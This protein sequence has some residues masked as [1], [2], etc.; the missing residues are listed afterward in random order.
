MTVGT[1]R[2]QNLG[3]G[4]ALELRR[5]H[6]TDPLKWAVQAGTDFWILASANGQGTA[7]GQNLLTDGGWTATSIAAYADGA[8]A[9]FMSRSD[10][11]TI[12]Q[13]TQNAQNDLLKS[14]AIFGSYAH[15]HAAAVI[16]G[17]RSLPRYLVCDA[18]AQFSVVANDEPTTCIGFV[19]DGGSIVTAN[20]SLG[21]ISSNGTS[22]VVQANGSE[23]LSGA[24]AIST[25]PTWFRILMDVKQNLVYAY[26]NGTLIGSIAITADE[27]PVAFGA[28]SGGAN[29]L[30]QLNQAHIFYA[31]SYPFDPQGF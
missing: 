30:I 28:G 1:S 16:A 8:A 25:S 4:D 7:S 14:P 13:Y 26:A 10:P 18:Y 5:V 11:G 23:N 3:R 21:C 17:M 12:A 19:E 6:V 27:F 9:D 24:V 15:A 31:W 20:D 29:N 22:W 2:P